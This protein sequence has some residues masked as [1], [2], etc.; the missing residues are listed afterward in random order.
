MADQT[1]SLNDLPGD[2]L[3]PERAS[4][5]AAE[6]QRVVVADPGV[7]GVDETL[8]PQPSPVGDIGT[9]AHEPEE[10]VDAGGRSGIGSGFSAMREVQQAKKEHADARNKLARLQAEI[11]SDN[12]TLE[13]RRQ[14]ERDYESI[15]AGQQ[16]IVERANTAISQLN[17]QVDSA[18]ATIANLKDQLSQLKDRHAKDLA[19]YRE[20][21][22]A[23]KKRADG[24]AAALRNAKRA[25][26]SADRRL[27]DL[28]KQR[29]RNISQ[30]NAAAQNA[31]EQLGR[32]RDRLTELNA[33]PVANAGEIQKINAEMQAQ[34]SQRE[35]A[36]ARAQSLPTTAS[37][38]IEAAQGALSQANSALQAAKR[39]NDASRKEAAAKDDEYKNLRSKFKHEEDDLDD[40]IVEVQKQLRQLNAQLHSAQDDLDAAQAAID[41][42]EAIHASPEMTESLANK[43]ADNSAAA[44]VQR[45]QVDALA[46]NERDVRQRTRQSRVKAI[47]IIILAVIVVLA[48]IALVLFLTGQGG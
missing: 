7:V 14:I 43:V 8:A 6:P 20:L 29:D 40:R 9:D 21:S 42:A 5:R 16:Q 37:A 48:I 26:Q 41:E 2:G 24:D 28:T 34:T 1:P 31:S 12:Q 11:D 19:P 17:G 45:Q 36:Q 30:A 15:V 35:Q 27:K 22:D 3:G 4:A 47:A 39:K 33:D 10:L 13:H 32:L 44:A 46:Q 18:N 25:A 23:A 38:D